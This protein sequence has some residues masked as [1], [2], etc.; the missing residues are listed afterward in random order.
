MDVGFGGFRGLPQ[1]PG[2]AC[3]QVHKIQSIG[4]L[5]SRGSLD[6]F[7]YGAFRSFLWGRV[8]C[9]VPACLDKSFANQSDITYIFL[10]CLEGLGFGGFSKSWACLS[11]LNIS[12]RLHA[13]TG[14]PPENISWSWR[15]SPT[16]MRAKRIII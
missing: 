10:F 7:A 3:C 8:L 6:Q 15:I 13:G 12:I 5:A 11:T 1:K 9:A 2:T 14:S 16:F 4:N